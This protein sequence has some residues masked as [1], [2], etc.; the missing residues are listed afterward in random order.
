MKEVVVVETAVNCQDVFSTIEM[1][2]GGRGKFLVLRTRELWLCMTIL[3]VGCML[4]M[5]LR[6]RQETWIAYLFA[7]GLQAKQALNL[8]E[9]L[10]LF[11]T[12]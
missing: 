3:V 4:V 6:N 11:S 12:S 5:L 7:D 9:E 8:T 1:V 2:Q 10:N